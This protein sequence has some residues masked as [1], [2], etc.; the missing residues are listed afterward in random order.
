MSPSLRVLA[1][2]LPC[3]RVVPRWL[4]YLYH[5]AK[6]E[7]KF[8]RQTLLDQASRAPRLYAPFV[9]PPVRLRARVHGS[10]DPDTFVANARDNATAIVGAIR[11]HR[12]S[13]SGTTRILDWGCG[14]GRVLQALYLDNFA[15]LLPSERPLLF[16]ADVDRPAVVWASRHH[17]FGRFHATKPLPPLP[18]EA[19]FF[20]LIIG[21][22]VF[23]H[24]DQTY[25]FAWLA[26]LRRIL[27]PG[28]VM[29]LTF[30]GSFP[31]SIAMKSHPEESAR[32]QEKGMV[33]RA[34]KG[35]QWRA[36]LPP[37]YGTTYHTERY[38][39]STYSE[40]FTLLEYIERGIRNYQDLVVL[41]RNEFT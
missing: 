33:F 10:L 13:M 27:R 30:H 25:E 12:V 21:I 41:T 7:V 23:T 28:G 34:P 16:G 36:G 19:A 2:K 35:S 18:F 17:P 24:L 20:S 11:R 22:S 8:L 5:W 40:G 9:L 6:S 37:F 29:L 1:Q 38:I 32:L 14:S 4:L 39:R 3:L 15:R 26:E 31:A